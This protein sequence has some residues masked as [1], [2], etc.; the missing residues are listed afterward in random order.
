[1]DHPTSRVLA[2]LHVLHARAAGEM[3]IGAAELAAGLEVDLRTVRR[4]VT[5]LRDAGV[6][7]EG[8]PGRDGG[9]RLRPGYRLPPLALAADEAVAVALGL[10]LARR[11]GPAGAAPA[12]ALA[13]IERG[14]P[15]ALGPQVRALA[16][17]VVIDDPGDGPVGGPDWNPGEPNPGVILALA[18]GAAEGRRTTLA[19]RDRHGAAT[20]RAV[21][22]YAVVRLRNRAWYAVGHCHLRGEVRAFRLDR[23]EAAAA[24]GTPFARP[25]GFDALA[26]LRQ[27]FARLPAPWSVEVA[28]AAP[29]AAIHRWAEPLF[30]EVVEED[31]TTVVRCSASD[32]DWLARTLAAQ[33]LAF[34]VCRPPELVAALARVRDGLNRAIAASGAR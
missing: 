2:L 1:M 24:E 3:A 26:Y 15:E 14:L 12:A 9:Y 10:R 13:K 27:S 31:A 21:D 34:R 20:A 17:A 32:L 8:R 28:F 4:Y 30:V 33:P 6:P 22:P 19:Y 18:V 11:Y 16:E 29:A 25:A 7:I 5:I 23:V